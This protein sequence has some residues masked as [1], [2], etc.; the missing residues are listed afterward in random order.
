MFTK[1]WEAA[2]TC[3]V[4]VEDLFFVFNARFSLSQ[5]AAIE[6]VYVGRV[7]CSSPGREGQVPLP[8]PPSHNNFS[9][10][11]P[12]LKK[13]MVRGRGSVTVLAARVWSWTAARAIKGAKRGDG[14]VRRRIG[15]VLFFIHAQVFSLMR[16]VLRHLSV[17]DSHLIAAVPSLHS[18]PDW[19]PLGYNLAMSQPAG[20]IQINLAFRL[21]H[22]KFTALNWLPLKVLFGL[23]SLSSDT[24]DFIR[25]TPG[26]SVVLRTEKQSF[27]DYPQTL[28][29]SA[30]FII[31]FELAPHMRAICR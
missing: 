13:L 10:F 26:S 9:F 18:F 12:S 29:V 6:R 3:F 4:I 31:S 24:R 1:F 15:S 27:C 25:E 11:V 21:S 5:Q 22:S 30:G 2:Q 20:I 19:N 17:S 14:C 8:H 7:H 16:W 28:S 23:G